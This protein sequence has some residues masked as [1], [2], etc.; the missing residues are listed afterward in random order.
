MGIFRGFVQQPGALLR[1]TDARSEV[2]R[3]LSGEDEDQRVT[4]SVLCFSGAKSEC[5]VRG[6]PP[7]HPEEDFTDGLVVRL[8]CKWRRRL[9]GGWRPVGRLSSDQGNDEPVW[10]L[11]HPGCM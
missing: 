8:L 1:V 2:E 9:K 4:V 11:L 3:A 10:A 7:T 6:A 5:E